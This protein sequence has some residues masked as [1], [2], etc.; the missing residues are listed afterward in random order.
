[1][2]GVPMG[3]HKGNGGAT[4]DIVGGA[5]P[6]DVRTYELTEEG[7]YLGRSSCE[8][9][10][11][12]IESGTVQVGD[13]ADGLAATRPASRSRFEVIRTGER[14]PIPQQLRYAIGYRDKFRCKWCGFRH[15]LELD[16]VIPWS[17]GGEDIDTNLR[18]LCHGCNT[19]RSNFHSD[20]D[21]AEISP[22]TMWCTICDG[23]GDDTADRAYC[24][25]CGRPSLARADQ[26]RQMRKYEWR[27]EMPWPAW[28]LWLRT[29]R[30]MRRRETEVDEW[31]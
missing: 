18:L 22:L 12:E 24:V 6:T 9:N 30:Q 21:S 27:I 15:N 14:D 17:N 7:S 3:S 10:A 28:K 29:E 25:I 4:T 23:P 2:I 16:H 31:S 20:E 5:T 13:E 8:S 1:M 26:L 11:R 19:S